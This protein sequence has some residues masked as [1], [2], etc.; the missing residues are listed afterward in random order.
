[1]RLSV[2]PFALVA[3]TPALVVFAI[4]CGSELNGGANVDAT[5]TADRREQAIAEFTAEAATVAAIG[6]PQSTSV[7]TAPT[8]A[9]SPTSAI[10]GPS[11]SN[12]GVA[13]DNPDR[14]EIEALLAVRSHA[15]STGDIDAWYETCA[16]SVRAL[17]RTAQ[18]IEKQVRALNIPT[19]GSV[20]F[21]L[22]LENIIITGGTSATVIWGLQWP[23]GYVPGLGGPYV[24]EDGRWFS[25]GWG[26]AG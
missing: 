25:V 4:A 11:G 18:A 24:K 23:N 5:A 3:A 1:M 2:K 17:G 15:M 9:A 16:P 10:T 19:D 13:A 20:E 22:V 14:L 7:V 6:S 12:S 8:T 26:C 21:E